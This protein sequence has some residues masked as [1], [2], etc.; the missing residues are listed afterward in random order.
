MQA[1]SSRTA[2]GALLEDEHAA[3]SALPAEVPSNF[4]KRHTWA[5]RAP[6]DTTPICPNC[7]LLLLL[8]VAGHLRVP[9]DLLPV[10]EDLLHLHCH[11][12]EGQ[13]HFYEGAPT[14]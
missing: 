13:W 12:S 10:K 2:A 9:D 6:Q 1:P 5:S 7:V 11:H 4:H 14:S 3:L 8:Q